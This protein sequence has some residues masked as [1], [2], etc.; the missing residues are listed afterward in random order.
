MS[1]THIPARGRG[2]LANHGPRRTVTTSIHYGSLVSVLQG[3]PN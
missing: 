2:G 3:D 1:V